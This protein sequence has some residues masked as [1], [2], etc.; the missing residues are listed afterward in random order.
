M[1]QGQLRKC[2][3]QLYKPMPL[4]G[5]WLQHQALRTLAEDGS[6]PAVRVLGEAIVDS[7]G[8]A[9]KEAAYD[10][11]RD[12]AAAGNVPAREAICRLVT[13]HNH[14]AA[15]KT[16]LAS[17]Y[18]P[19]D[20]LNRALFLFLTSQW[21][22]Y[23]TL[24]VD[25]RLLKAAYD[26]ADT[27]LRARIAARARAAGRFEWVDMVAGGK[28]ARRVAAMTDAEWT[29]ALAL[30]ERGER[31]D[32]L[33][34]LAQEAPA[35]WSVRLLRS[36]KRGLR[37]TRVHERKGCDELIRLAKKWK[38]A[39]LEPVM[40]HRSTLEGHSREV[41]CLAFDGAGAILA[42]G[43]ADA[44]VR[45]WEMPEGRPRG[46]LAGHRGWINQLA[47]TPDGEILASVARDGRI[48][49][50]RLPDGKRLRKK[51]AHEGAV[52]GLALSPHG[53]LL[54]TGGADRL[55][56]LWSLPRAEQLAT[57]KKHRA[58]VSC[59]AI[60]PDGTYLAS[61]SA[62]S[63]VCIWL[64]P[65]GKLLC[66]L[67]EHRDEQND[68]ILAVAFSPDG[69]M[70]ASSGTDGAIRIWSVPRG[71]QLRNLRTHT[72]SAGSLAFSR[73]GAMLISAGSDYA[74]QIW[75]VH[76][77]QVLK[78]LE[79]H[80]TENSCVAMSRDGGFLVTSGS[81]GA[82]V[83]HTIR[84]WSLRDSQTVRSLCGH[85]RAITSL[86]LSPDGRLLASGSGDSTIRIWSAE[87]A[88]LAETSA[89]RLSLRDLEMAQKLLAQ[90]EL[91][92]AERSDL[93]F[94]A[95]LLRW[96]MRLDIVIDEAGPKVIEL[97]EFDI[98]IEG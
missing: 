86:A 93:E 48:C 46:V 42:S 39:D 50:W 1:D 60:S 96:R 41:R 85:Q 37:I 15:R 55:V 64:L 97:G 61:G 73:D 6:A 30:L 18:L 83:D 19:H 45:L 29:T 10:A 25:H 72:G 51:K 3:Q 77:G 28:Q 74:V 22:K 78:F 7:A 2:R 9:L 5:G 91:T 23:D 75:D 35:R 20:D 53:D 70:L 36:L 34:R 94:V 98:E 82:D 89:A 27:R 16:A 59:L 80:I 66:T 21:S 87:L 12:I 54:A 47:L 84:I 57:L 65:G 63:D 38:Q 76:T 90:E 56:K 71:R 58:A 4:I 44:T 79:A 24:D 31:W 49:L 17:G 67:E 26:N 92:E 81:S 43:S 8:K 33:W 62:D 40:V 14:A 52:F 13:R 11:L 95:A 68:G 32:D 69:Q 88:R